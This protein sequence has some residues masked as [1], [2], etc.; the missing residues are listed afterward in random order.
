MKYTMGGQ[1]DKKCE[2]G[3]ERDG[4]K[5]RKKENVTREKGK[6]TCVTSR[7]TACVCIVIQ[8]FT[9]HTEALLRPE[10]DIT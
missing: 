9:S 10:K 4:D 7:C 6:M 5:T 8:D 1:G 3:I 2:A